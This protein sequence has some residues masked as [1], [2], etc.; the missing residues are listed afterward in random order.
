MG[1]TL[2]FPKSFQQVKGFSQL[3]YRDQFAAD[4]GYGQAGQCCSEIIAPNGLHV[5]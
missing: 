3:S 5:R 2:R 1:K 4:L